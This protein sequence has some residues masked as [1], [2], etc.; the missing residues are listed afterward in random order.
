MDRLI[1][2][3]MDGNDVFD[4]RGEF[5]DNFVSGVSLNG[6]YIVR[7][8]WSYMQI[9]CCLAEF[10]EHV[11]KEHMET[12]GDVSFPGNAIVPVVGNFMGQVYIPYESVLNDFAKQYGR[13]FEFICES[14][15]SGE[16]EFHSEIR[17][18]KFKIIS[19]LVHLI[20]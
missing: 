2:T 20:V 8:Y 6:T 13:K 15:Y 19:V 10:E 12:I 11:V 3:D 1:I 9:E 5:V 14:G 16:C 18:S 17:G 7:R 4:A